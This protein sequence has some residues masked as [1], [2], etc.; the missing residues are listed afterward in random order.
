MRQCVRRKQLHAPRPGYIGGS[1]RTKIGGPQSHIYAL[2]ARSRLGRSIALW[3]GRNPRRAPRGG[4]Q[5]GAHR[6]T[7]GQ[8][9]QLVD[10]PS[11]NSNELMVGT[12]SAGCLYVSMC[13]RMLGMKRAEMRKQPMAAV[14]GTITIHDSSDCTCAPQECHPYSKPASLSEFPQRRSL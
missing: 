6:R 12:A 4:T 5:A 2:P 1:A 11:E 3:G 10:L 8:E 7:M 9:A 14:H 13:D